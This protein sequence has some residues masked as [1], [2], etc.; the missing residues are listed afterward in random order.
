M[1]H[2]APA[3]VAVSKGTFGVDSPGP[4]IA[5]LFQRINVT[6]F[7]AIAALDRKKLYRFA[8]TPDNGSGEHRP[9]PLV[10]APALEIATGSTALAQWHCAQLG[11][12]FV[13]PP[14]VAVSASTV[15]AQTAT[16]TAEF[17]DV[18]REVARS[19]DDGV[20]T[21]PERRVIVRHLREL[22]AQ[23]EALA[24]LVTEP[25]KP[26]ASVRADEPTTR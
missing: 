22:Q 7:A 19:L 3:A 2:A 20:L 24:M 9:L 11:G 8:A 17:S 12:L 5:A 13:R 25:R 26:L 15:L 10:L 1:P 4:L 6:A 16:L 23:A 21:M 14:R 18:Q